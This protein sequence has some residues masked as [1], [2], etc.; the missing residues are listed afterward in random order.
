MGPPDTSGIDLNPAN[1]RSRAD[2]VYCLQQLH[3]TIGCPSYRD[4]EEVGKN[5]GIELRSSTIGD[6]IGENSATSTRKVMWK[7]V[8]LFVLACGVPETE[9]DRWR[10]AWE[11][12]MAP[13]KPAWQEERQHLMAEIAQLKTD[14]AATEARASQLATDLAAA[15]A[16]IEQLTTPELTA[17]ETPVDQPAAAVKEVE[18]LERLRIQADTRHDH[19]DYAGAADLY[20]HIVTQVER[21]H[22]SGDP[23]TLQAQR[24]LL[25]I[26]TEAYTGEWLDGEWKFN[27]W[28][29]LVTRRTLNARWRHLIRQ[30]QK[31]LPEGDRRTLELRLAHIYWGGVLLL[32]HTYWSTIPSE[33]RDKRSTAM[34]PAARKLLIGLHADCKIHLPPGDPFTAQVAEYVDAPGKLIHSRPDGDR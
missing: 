15:E 13:D 23:R 11:A 1:F 29:R 30:Y 6:L 2:L 17:G 34:L 7:T 21:E 19:K 22:G 31:H 25:E 33:E 5:M 14:L 18:P 9:L 16:R 8:E 3:T 32:E 24:R 4:L 26:E 20:K 10:A 27:M 28:F 12:A